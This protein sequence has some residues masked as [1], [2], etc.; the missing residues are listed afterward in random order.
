[1]QNPWLQSAAEWLTLLQPVVWALVAWAWWS[2]KRTFVTEE[3]CDECRKAR[4]D[5]RKEEAAGIQA[6]KNRQIADDAER[7]LIAQAL[8][9]MPCTTDIQQIALAL[10]GVKGSVQAIKVQ[11]EGHLRAMDKL[12]KQVELLNRVHM[13]KK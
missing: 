5:Q 13:E 9:N 6:M 12:E 2:F 1:M 10:E 11:G 4:D 3:E 8:K 7:K